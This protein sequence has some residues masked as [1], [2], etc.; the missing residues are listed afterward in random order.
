M[1]HPMGNMPL[2]TPLVRIADV[3]QKEWSALRAA[4]EREN[5]DGFRAYVRFISDPRYINANEATLRDAFSNDDPVLVLAADAIT[6]AHSER[7][8][9]VVDPQET[10]PSFRVAIEHLW[11]VEN[12]IS[13]GNL[14]FEEF[15]DALDS[16]GWFRPQDSHFL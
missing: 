7:S 13:I 9:L 2:D 10:Q 14:L 15:T 16:D 1:V 8:V 4:V 6:F 3:S 12:N 5:A 11:I